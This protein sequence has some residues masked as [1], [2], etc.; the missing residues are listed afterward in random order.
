MC[1]QHLLL[2][3]ATLIPLLSGCVSIA[4]TP[5]LSVLDATQ[6]LPVSFHGNVVSYRAESSQLTGRSAAVIVELFTKSSLHDIAVAVLALNPAV[7]V[8]PVACKFKVLRPPHVAH[9][10]RPPYPLPAVPLCTF[11]VTAPSPGRYP[12]TLQIRDSG[13]SDLLKPMNVVVVIKGEKP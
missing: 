5:S 8:T 7:S 9:A 3:L 11:V 4:S 1:R 13:G 12:M 6:N 2:F 10:T